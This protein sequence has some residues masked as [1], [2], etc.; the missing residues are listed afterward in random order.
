MKYL[1]MN[2]VRAGIT[3]TPEEYPFSSYGGWN[4][5]GQHPYQNNFF[6]HISKLANS[7]VSLEDLRDL[8]ALEMKQM[9]LAD[10]ITKLED[11]NKVQEAF[12]LRGTL[13][14]VLRQES[15][16]SK[17]E[18]IVLS[19]EDF[20]SGHIIGSKEYIKEKYRRWAQDKQIA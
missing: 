6:Q 10:T 4:K 15:Y 19:K 14:E 1:E 5:E 20:L 11:E 18:I 16:Q 9:R 7:K 17:A 12:K 13:E 2:P 3:E 8:M